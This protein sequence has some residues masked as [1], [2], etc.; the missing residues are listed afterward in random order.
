MFA[1]FR[2]T[3]E[4]KFGHHNAFQLIRRHMRQFDCH[5]HISIL[6]FDKMLSNIA[7]KC[8]CLFILLF[9][10][11]FSFSKLIRTTA[12]N[13]LNPKKLK[14]ESMETCYWVPSN[15]L[16]V[17]IQ[18][19][20]KKSEGEIRQKAKLANDVDKYNELEKYYDR[21]RHW[22]H[23]NRPSNVHI[24]IFKFLRVRK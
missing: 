21:I 11:L 22:I 23:W 20:I 9:E 1:E 18:F 4:P 5:R 2:F 3:F 8:R 7:H 14:V 19:S 15:D 24:P 10:F 6:L 16:R 17:F 12:K 13:G